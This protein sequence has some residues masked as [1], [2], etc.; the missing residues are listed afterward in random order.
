VATA[1]P[2]TEFRAA[3]LIKHA[4]SALY[5]AKNAGRDRVQSGGTV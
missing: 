2:A 3:G 1:G 4:D 5:R